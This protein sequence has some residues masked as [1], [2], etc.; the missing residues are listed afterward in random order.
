MLVERSS[1]SCAPPPN[2]SPSVR[3][4]RWSLL[5]GGGFSYNRSGFDVT[6][7]CGAAGGRKCAFY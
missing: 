5:W 6:W 4:L 1:G 3:M 2:E 7:G